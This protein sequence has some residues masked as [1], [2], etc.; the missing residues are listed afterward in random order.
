MPQLR[1]I[2]EVA[3]VLGEKSSA[4]WHRL[5]DQ[6]DCCYEP[7][8]LPQELNQ[9]RQLVARNTLNEHGPGWPG[10]IDD[11]PVSLEEDFTEVEKIAWL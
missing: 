5:L 7:V 6:V 10:W 2:E 11:R 8:Y 9:H 4:H 1:L 3:T